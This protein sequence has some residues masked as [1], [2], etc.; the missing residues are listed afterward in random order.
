MLLRCS[1]RA[2]ALI[3]VVATLIGSILFSEPDRADAFSGADFDPGYIISDAQF[4]ATDVMSQGQI[5]AFLEAQ[6]GSCSNSLCLNVLKVDT[7]TTTLEFGTCATYS[8]EAGEPA[9][10]IIYKV[11]QACAISAKVILATLQKEQGLVTSKAPTSGVLRKAMGQGCPDTAQ[12]DSAFYGFF[13]QVLSGARQLAWYGNPQGSH[14]SIKVGQL[15]SVRYSPTAS[16]GSSNVQIRNRATA[17]LYYYTPY[18]PNAAAM[19]NLRGSGDACSSYGNRNFWVNYTTWFGPA[20][21][22]GPAQIDAAYSNQ[23]G[24]AGVLGEVASAYLEP[25]ANGGGVARAYANGSIYWT[26]AASA[27]VMTGPIRDYYFVKAGET[28]PLGWPISDVLTSSANGGGLGQAFQGG[29]VYWTSASGAHGVSSNIRAAYHAV[30]GE[31]GPLGWPTTE[32]M[33]VAA[34][35]GGL[36]QAFRGG[37]VYAPN[38]QPARAVS[39]EIQAVYLAA[40]GE[41][42]E[43]GWPVSDLILVSVNGGGRGQ[44]FSNGSIYSSAGRGTFAVQ[45]AIRTF[46]FSQGGEGGSLGWPTSAKQC[47]LPNGACLQSFQ[48]G[49]L[50]LASGGSVRVGSP[51]IEAV[52]NA[53]GGTSGPLGDRTSGVLKI[54]ANGGGLGQAFERGS[55]YWTASHG[56]FVVSGKIRDFYFS[57]SGEAGRLGWP[58]GAQVCTSQNECSQQFQNNA[59][60]WTSGGGA[61]IAS[62]EI[63]SAYNSAGGPNGLLMLRTSNLLT[64]TAN[65]GGLGQAY[66]GGSIYWSSGRGAFLVTG[67]TR[68]FYFS[69]GGETGALGWPAA[70]AVCESDGRCTQSFQNGSIEWSPESGGRVVY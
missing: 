14:T 46:Y 55:I 3:L 2:S 64:S 66:Q 60:Y 12:C 61:R 54:S 10:R 1:V 20:T 63:E 67:G 6:I 43:L 11:Q 4:Y 17:S 41:I 16:C 35:G 32:A 26:A 36:G 65:G 5:Q 57:Q 22:P 18:Q 15:N 50:Y 9:A 23:G 49:T 52:Y 39:G 69:L 56:G 25:G 28:G 19:A 48:G 70:S 37:S 58:H 8:G 38:G 31:T 7:P 27:R 44:A 33:N 68:N 47:G 62:S 30:G 53:Q 34:N 42:G 59:I 13:I 45:G 29:S 24:S 51:E 40:N 21:S